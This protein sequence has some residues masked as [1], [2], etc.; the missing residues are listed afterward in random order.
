MPIWKCEIPRVHPITKTGNA[1]MPG[2]YFIKGLLLSITCKLQFWLFVLVADFG[3]ILGLFVGFSFMTL[4]DGLSFLI[5]GLGRIRNVSCLH[6]KW[7]LTI[8]STFSSFMKPIKPL[9]CTEGMNLLKTLWKNRDAPE[10]WKNLGMFSVIL[11][12]W[13]KTWVMRVVPPVQLFWLSGSEWTKKDA[14]LALCFDPI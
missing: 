7:T 8:N 5:K 9:Q 6:R 1:K 11:I 13:L 10:A 3:G 14:T 4:W 2:S 12:F